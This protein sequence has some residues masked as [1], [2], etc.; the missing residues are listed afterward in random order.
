M[1][2]NTL[3]FVDACLAG[4]RLADEIDDFVDQW[5]EGES[6]EPL[7]DFLGFTPEEYAV[8]IKMPDSLEWILHARR[9]GRPIFALLEEAGS[10][11]PTN[12][13]PALS[14]EDVAELAAWLKRMGRTR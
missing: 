12:A 13:L 4:D 10:A 9:T 14:P 11:K 6:Q 1:S 3:R 2:R 5:H 7:S 8:W